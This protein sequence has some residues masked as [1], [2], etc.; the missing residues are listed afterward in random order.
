MMREGDEMIEEFEELQSHEEDDEEDDEDEEDYII[1]NS[2]SSLFLSRNQHNYHQPNHILPINSSPTSSRLQ[3]VV[4]TLVSTL[5]FLRHPSDSQSTRKP[6]NTSIISIRLLALISLG[7]S[8]F[9]VLL[10]LVGKPSNYYSSSTSYSDRFRN[11]Q[12]ASSSSHSGKR[13]ISWDD[14]N[15][16]QPYTH[17]IDWLTE[18]GDGV[19]SEIALDGIL[20]TDLNSNSK[21]YLIRTKDLIDNEGNRVSPSKF[22]V[23]SDLRYV[24]IP[25][26]IKK[27]WRYSSFGI[28]WIFD[29]EQ[30]TVTSLHSQRSNSDPQISIAQWSPTGHSIA[31]VFRNDIYLITN[32]QR[33]SDPLRL[34]KTGTST[35]FNGVCD[36]VYEEE[37]FSDST[38]LWWSPDSRK[39]VWLSSDESEV[40]DYQLTVYNPSTT[41]GR[42]TPYKNKKFMKYPKP[43]YENPIVALRMFDL[44]GYERSLASGNGKKVEVD[45]FIRELKLDGAIEDKE[46][47][48]MEVAWVSDDE[49]I[50]REINRIATIEKTGYFR[51]DNS[52]MS[53]VSK[54]RGHE[55]LGKV[56]MDLDYTKIDGGWAEPGQFIRPITPVNSKHDFEPGYLDIRIDPQG[57]R[58]VAYFSPSDSDR[59]IFLS[60]GQWEVD[61][62]ILAVDLD[63]RLVYFIGANP[64][65]E[66]HLYSVR[67]PDRE[68]LKGLRNMKGESE[69]RNRNGISKVTDGVGY[70]SAEFS[71]LGGF[72]L[73]SYSGPDVP[74]QKLIKVDDHSFDNMIEENVGLKRSLQE[75]DLPAINYRTVKNSIGQ[76]MNVR[77]ILPVDMDFSGRTKY[78]V[79]FRVYG[80]PN[81][82]MASKRFGIDWNDYLSSA[83]SYIIVNIDGRGTG[84][85]GRSFRVGVRNRLGELESLDMSTAAKFYAKLK[86]VDPD[87]IGIWGWSYGG[88]LTCKT[89]ESYSSVF[90]MA[91]A[92]APVTD[93]RYY[94]SIYTERYMSTPHLNKIGYERSAVSRIDGF[95]N[96]SFS[97]AHGSA[98]DNVHFLNSAELLDRLTYSKNHDFQ[99]RLFIDSDHSIRT[100]GAHDELMRWMTDY[101][102]LKWG[103]GREPKPEVIKRPIFNYRKK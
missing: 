89:A 50:V 88:Y 39:I 57:Y 49:L 2:V 98:D 17:T 82:Q 56:V 37:V 79:L 10:Y 16:F 53:N 91:L 26:T 54:D 70:Y 34:T 36:W 44:D 95:K 51:F 6:V 96:L 48:I 75:F 84:F 62:K 29:T 68:E 35:I 43:G 41:A 74:W 55:V 11:Y 86:Y 27:Q 40:R 31:Y 1:S 23:S 19:Y 20:L 9:G 83:L 100:R 92:V 93:W 46:R 90:S 42:V 13:L 3:S 47:I 94:D 97:L 63:R 5:S 30:K 72:Y 38:A 14:Y 77:E 4:D 8:T 61:E 80:G 85:R 28:Y 32:P 76:D 24:M 21:R 78:P 52:A 66:R 87:R 58:H 81:S 69:G 18:A 102:I 7:L 71:G 15:R 45:D 12:N 22:T 73:L 59:P 65:T 103:D 101:L 33:S 99:F 60:S 25:N 67:L 64:S